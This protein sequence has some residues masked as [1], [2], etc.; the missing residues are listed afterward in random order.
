MALAD[1]G[2]LALALVLDLAWG[3]PPHRFHP[4][5]WLGR[6]ISLQAQRAPRSGAVV[7]F[8][9]G[10]GMALLDVAL[11]TMPGYWLLHFLSETLGTEE[12]R[13]PVAYIIVGALLLKTAFSVRFLGECA[14]K[15]KRLLLANQV[16]EAR[17]HLRSLVSRDTSA[18]DEP[19]LVSATVESVAENTCDSFVASVFYFLILGVPGALAYRAVNTLDAMI[20]YH[21]RYEYLGKFA[22][23]LDDILNYI[24]ARLTGLFLV[25]AAFLGKKDGANGWRILRRDHGRTK[26][27]NAGWP[28]S[29]MAGALNVRLEKGGHYQLGDERCPL[30]PDK[31]DTS[32]R[33]MGTA[34]IIWLIIS[35]AV[36]GIRFAYFT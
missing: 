32:L 12:V 8:I 9:Y 22:A 19:H 3:E 5:A 20:G 34:V 27:P 30:G 18:L 28:M 36:V 31:I 16:D 2:I 15:I 7:Q 35:L 26:S 13:M 25:L 17:F 21:G 11:F 23:R 24:P 4:V 14:I 6:L 1:A 10:A 29:A 33:L